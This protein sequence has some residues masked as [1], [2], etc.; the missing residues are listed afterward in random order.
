MANLIDLLLS[1]DTAQRTALA[2]VLLSITIYT[3]RQKN[4]LHYPSN[5]SRVRENGRTRFSLKTRLAY[6]TDCQNLFNEAYKTVS[7]PS[8]L[9][10]ISD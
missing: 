5:L 1:L 2:F 8:D 10:I 6:Y 3:I 9:H 7:P 4:T